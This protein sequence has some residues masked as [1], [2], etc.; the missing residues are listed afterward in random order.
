MNTLMPWRGFGGLRKEMDDMFER[1]FERPG[2]W[3]SE[4]GK[5][6]PKLDVSETKDAVIVKAEVPGIDQKDIGVSL[7]GD[8]LTIKG[9]KTQEKEEKDATYYRVERAYGSF[10]RT[11][12][13]PAPV[14]ASKVTATFKNG[15]LTVTLP[16]AAGA[17]GTTIPIK[18]V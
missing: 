11:V 17:K 6:S 7:Q 8:L 13:M 9:E 5:W 16:K 15:L 2:E 3:T 10:M 4:F 1:F 18:D 12:P 14:E